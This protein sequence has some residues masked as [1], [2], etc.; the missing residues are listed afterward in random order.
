MNRLD[1]KFSI[2]V[3]DDEEDLC[4][5]LQFNLENEGFRVDVAYSSEEALKKDLTSFDFFILDIMM[6]KISGTELAKMIK[7]D[8]RLKHKPII[9]LTAK[10]TEMDKLIGFRIGADDYIAKPFSVKEVVARLQ[11]IGSRVY[12]E[13]S[14]NKIIEFKS[15]KI[16]DN[17]KRVTMDGQDL[18]LTKKEFDILDLLVR[19]QGRIFSRELILNLVWEDDGEIMDRTVDVNIRRIR[20]K[21]EPYGKLIKTRSGYGYYFDKDGLSSV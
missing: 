6:G 7:R 10:N 5:I 1:S 3:V 21:I 16:D 14:E 9:F 8:D 13:S 15:L 11:A 17:L 20:K 12:Q 4:E 2:L 18:S 19:N